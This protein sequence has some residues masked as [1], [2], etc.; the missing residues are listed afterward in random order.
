MGKGPGKSSLPC[1]VPRPQYF[2]SVI[3]F[4]WP[5]IR[6]RN[7]VTTKAW[8][9]A[10]QEQG[11]HLPTTSQKDYAKTYPRLDYQPLFGKGARAPPPNSP[12]TREWQKS[13]LD[14]PVQHKF[15]SYLFDGRTEFFCFFFNPVI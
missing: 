1:L 6:C 15:E 12:D 3:R 13:S 14:L 9:K 4:W 2:A 8:E 11:N 5:G 10:V 7:Q